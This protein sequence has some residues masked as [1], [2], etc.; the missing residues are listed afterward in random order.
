M[1]ESPVT[2]ILNT[3]AS[4]VS[5]VPYVKLSCLPASDSA[6]EERVFMFLHQVPENQATFHEKYGTEEPQRLHD[7][8]YVGGR[9]VI[10]ILCTKWCTNIYD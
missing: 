2:F 7:I 5:P 4:L 9:D 3:F 8:K 10:G 1:F 6:V